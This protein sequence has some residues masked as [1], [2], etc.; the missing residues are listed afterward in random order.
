MKF[1]Q[2]AYQTDAVNAVVRLFEGQSNKR[3]SF[4]LQTQGANRF[5]GNTLDLADEQIGENLKDVQKTFG[6]SETEIG[7]HGLNFSVEMETGTGKTYVYLRTIF[8]LNRQYGW[9]KFVI[10]VPSVTI[11]EGVLQTLRATKNHFAGLFDKPVM[12]FSEC[13][14]I[15]RASC[16]E[17]V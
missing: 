17:R 15:G 11:R 10:V 16:R 7:M 4:S 12:N 5:V 13:A 6:Q 9:T 2:L 8:E 14:E 1:E 3:E